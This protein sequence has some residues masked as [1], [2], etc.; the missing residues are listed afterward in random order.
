MLD[1]MLR[2]RKRKSKERPRV[3][4]AQLV[5]PSK[6]LI[7]DGKEITIKEIKQVTDDSIIAE[8]LR[9]NIVVIPLKRGGG[10]GAGNPGTAL[11]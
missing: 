4:P 1:L 3:E 5:M 7:V 11:L 8:D 9:G 6:K 10:S 2:S